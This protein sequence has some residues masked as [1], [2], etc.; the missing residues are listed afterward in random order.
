M[1]TFRIVE[2][3][4]LVTSITALSMNVYAL[5]DAVRDSEFLFAK[6]VNG[7]LRLVADMNL[8]RSWL[9]VTKCTLNTLA[10]TVLLIANEAPSAHHVIAVTIWLMLSV[11]YVIEFAVARAIRIRLRDYPG[12]EK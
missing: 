1:I 7:P 6:K 5:V 11:I 12:G 9:L 3:A 2:Y 8:H 4:F 10:A